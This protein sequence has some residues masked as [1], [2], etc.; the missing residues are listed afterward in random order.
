VRFIDTDAAIEQRTGKEIAAIW[1]DVGEA[2]F[3]TIEQE[4]AL[5]A[6]GGPPSV[7]AFGG[8]AVTSR[9]LR[10][11]ALD[12]ATVVTLTAS[13]EAI[14]SRTAGSKRPL[15]A[16]PDLA[17]RIRDLLDARADAYAEHHATLDTTSI[18]VDDAARQLA[19][20]KGDDSL[21]VPLGRR[22]HRY[23]RVHGE[24]ALLASAVADL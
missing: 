18:A 14:A 22:S 6:L 7:I 13:I 9:A 24:P 16:G 10:F 4:V 11:A 21:V 20:L 5:D 15:L 17:Q 3:R 23:R 2:G 19:A 8:G 1:R 12:R